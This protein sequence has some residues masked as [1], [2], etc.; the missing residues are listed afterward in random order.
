MEFGTELMFINE[1]P[2]AVPG[3]L[4][5]LQLDPHLKPFRQ[6]IERRYVTYALYWDVLKII[7]PTRQKPD[8]ECT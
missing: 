5:L 6:E 1:A 7:M 8:M 3:M 4:T 2:S